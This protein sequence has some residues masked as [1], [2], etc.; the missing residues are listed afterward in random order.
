ML[1]LRTVTVRVRV[2]GRFVRV[3]VP[4]RWMFF[5][6]S[7]RPVIIRSGWD[8]GRNFTAVYGRRTGSLINVLFAATNLKIFIIFQCFVT[9]SVH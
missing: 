8:Y 6:L 1:G 3:P 7:V 4:Y 5:F 2:Y 9:I